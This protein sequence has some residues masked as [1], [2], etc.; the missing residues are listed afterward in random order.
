[1]TKREPVPTSVTRLD[2][3]WLRELLAWREANST[4]DAREFMRT[5]G[6]GYKKTRTRA[7]DDT[8]HQETT[9]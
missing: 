3:P 2:W 1:M 8:R 9:T 5:G 7:I 4:H 6:R